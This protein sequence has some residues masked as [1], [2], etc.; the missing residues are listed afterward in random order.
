[1]IFAIN[2]MQ[3][4]YVPLPLKHHLIFCIIATVVYILEIYK[5][6]TLNYL[7]VMLAVDATLLMQLFP[8]PEMVVSLAIMEAIWLSAALVLSIINYKKK[9]AAA[10]AD[11]QKGE[12]NEDSDT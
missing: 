1:M 11:Q 10:A 2:Q 8:S 4:V 9:K 7:F 12:G 3:N 6:R 5:K